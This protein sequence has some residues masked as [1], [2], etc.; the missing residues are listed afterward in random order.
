MTFLM[1]THKPL[2][3][4]Q[5]MCIWHD[6]TG[7]GDSASWYLN[8]VSVFDTQTKKCTFVGIGKN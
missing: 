4:L 2:G 8:Q 7:E 6:N 1:A 5:H 3:P